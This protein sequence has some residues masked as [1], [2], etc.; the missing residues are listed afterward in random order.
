MLACVGWG[1]GEGQQGD[2]R[3][4]CHRHRLAPEAK[5]LPDNTATDAQAGIAMHVA[6]AEAAHTRLGAACHQPS[7]PNGKTGAKTKTRARGTR[8]VGGGFGTHHGTCWP[9]PVRVKFPSH[10]RPVHGSRRGALAADATAPPF[11]SN[12]VTLTGSCRAEGP[13]RGGSERTRIPTKHAG[14][15]RLRQPC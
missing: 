10:L 14:P 2:G 7:A 5:P 1:P 6:V 11:H 4:A 8:K 13:V 3:H 15:K 9:R 12:S